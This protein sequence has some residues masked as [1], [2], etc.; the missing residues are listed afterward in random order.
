MGAS[1]RWGA[2]TGGFSCSGC[3]APGGSRPHPVR[4]G[5]G[6]LRPEGTLVV[7]GRMP[8]RHNQHESQ[9]PAAPARHWGLSRRLP[10]SLTPGSHTQAGGHQGLPICLLPW[11]PRPPTSALLHPLAPAPSTA[12]QWEVVAAAARLSATGS[13]GPLQCPTHSGDPRGPGRAAGAIPGRVGGC[14][15][16]AN[17]LRP[18][19][20]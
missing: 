6:P 12:L 20:C 9:S 19:P 13:W 5:S 4:S 14:T 17:C 11:T 16:L 1:W 15:Q 3:S 10:G 2:R 18:L 7:T 8:C